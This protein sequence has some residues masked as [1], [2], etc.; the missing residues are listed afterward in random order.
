MT[1]T[2]YYG[3]TMNAHANGNGNEMTHTTVRVTELVDYINGLGHARYAIVVDATDATVVTVV[4][5]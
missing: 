4:T 5:W 1:K 3:V 2:W